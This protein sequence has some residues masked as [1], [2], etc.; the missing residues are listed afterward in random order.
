MERKKE[1]RR[2][3]GR[4]SVGRK[5][6]SRKEARNLKLLYFKQPKHHEITD[7]T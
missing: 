7:P 3:E 2:E 5:Q 6:K 1:E 4:N